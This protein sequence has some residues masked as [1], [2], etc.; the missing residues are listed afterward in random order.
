[1]SIGIGA[2]NVVMV[3]TYLAKWINN[4]QGETCGAVDWCGVDGGLL[5]LVKCTKTKE[6]EGVEERRVQMLRASSLY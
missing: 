4:L 3:L 2:F 1:M 6:K 5:L